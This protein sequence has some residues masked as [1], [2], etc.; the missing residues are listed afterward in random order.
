[1]DVGSQFAITWFKAGFGTSW[2]QSR[3]MQYWWATGRI[4][5]K[6]HFTGT[7]PK[8]RNYACVTTHRFLFFLS[9]VTHLDSFSGSRSPCLISSS[10]SPPPL[11]RPLPPSSGHEGRAASPGH[12]GPSYFWGC[13]FFA[14]S[15]A[16]ALSLSLSPSPSL[17]ST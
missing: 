7:S 10:L 11:S 12:Q 1:M 3:T 4:R 5:I 17:S 2:N 6:R 8:K 14:R 15:L 13:L 16:L 9:R